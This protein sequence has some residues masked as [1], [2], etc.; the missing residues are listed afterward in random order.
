MAETDAPT[1][2]AAARPVLR[3]AII[4][5]VA[6]AGVITVGLAWPTGGWQRDGEPLAVAGW[7]PYWQPEA[8]LASFEANADLFAD[9]SVVAYSATAATTVTRYPAMT[10]EVLATFRNAAAAADVPLVATIFD[11]AEPNAMAAVLADPVARAA[12]VD[13][14]VG[15]ATT[16]SFD[17]VDLDYEKFAFEDGR[18]TWATTRPNW[19][20]FL[21]ELAAE[22]HAADVQ[23]IVSVPAVYDGG[24]TDASGYWV[25][26]YAAMGG[27]VD[28]IRV[29]AYDYSTLG[30]G[31]GPVAP[32]DWVRDLVT[33]ITALVPADKI[34]L[35]IPVYGYDWVVA[36]TGTCPPE[37]TP[38][39]DV[40]STQR[41]TTMI[42]ER[43][44]VPAWDEATGESTLD[45]TDTLSGT[46]AAGVTATCTVQRTVRFL[47]DRAV[48]LRA[49]LAHRS[50]LH[51]V[52]LWALGYDNDATWAAIRLAHRGTETWP[53][54]TVA[55]S[56][57]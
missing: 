11:E 45:Y 29:M 54:I 21:T 56:S 40:I 35:G 38:A 28:R 34:D 47:G 18:S 20:A 27:I 19:V 13:T 25:Y 6:L 44:L 30:S 14:I 36:V 12:H 4:G 39:N 51:G 1:G 15:I 41:L 24:Q 9:V 57:P 16:N 32:I 10:D 50:N 2:R 55:P 31:P 53:E 22:L 26:D 33:A 37:Q 42:A 23:L 49:A 48:H 5:L 3:T 8:S 7:A 46:D 43:G 17:G 52:A